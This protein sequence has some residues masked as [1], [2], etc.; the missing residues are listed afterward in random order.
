MLNKMKKRG[1]RRKRGDADWHLQSSSA[2]SC[3][4]PVTPCCSCA[5]QHVPHQYSY[6]M[7]LCGL[8]L[9]Y[10]LSIHTRTPSCVSL[11]WSGGSFGIFSSPLRRRVF[12]SWSFSF[13]NSQVKYSWPVAAI[14]SF[15]LN[16]L[17][18]SYQVFKAL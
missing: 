18:H 16:N 13:I 2:D 17:F 15:L 9:C 12:P 7:V 8:I 14:S 11:V 6:P 5:R 4:S 3:R 1:S 10:A